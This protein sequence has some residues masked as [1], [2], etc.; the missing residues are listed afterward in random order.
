MQQD[1]EYECMWHVLC[2][3]LRALCRMLYA[4][5]VIIPADAE[6]IDS[7]IARFQ[8]SAGS[9]P[10]NQLTVQHLLKPHGHPEWPADVAKTPH[11]NPNKP[12][13]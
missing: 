7:F 12:I 3:E 10:D 11:P 2:V 9:L 1:L 4:I 13:L 6:P 8:R 5:L